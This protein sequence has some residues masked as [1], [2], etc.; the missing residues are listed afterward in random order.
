M[1]A[2]YKHSER[3]LIIRQPWRESES[4]N[5]EGESLRWRNDARIFLTAL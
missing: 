1:E 2:A 5:R 3:N 4:E